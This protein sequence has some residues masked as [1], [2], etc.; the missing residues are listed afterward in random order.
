LWA[1]LRKLSWLIK[2]LLGHDAGNVAILFAICSPILVLGV[3]GGIDLARAYAG[4]QELTQVANLGCQ[5]ASRPSIIQLASQ[6]GGGPTYVSKVNGF[7]TASLTS[8][9]FAFTQSNSTPFSYTANGPANV[10]LNSTVPTVF[11]QIVHVTTIPISAT[12]HCYDTPSAVPQIVPNGNST[13]LVQEGFENTAICPSGYCFVNASGGIGTVATPTS[14]ASTTTSYT[15]ATGGVWHTTGY[16][17]EIDHVGVIKSTVAEGSFSAELDCDNGSGTAGNS[18]ISTEIY[19]PAGSY[20]LRYN[21][22]SRVDYPHYDPTYLCGTT[23]GDLTWANDTYSPTDPVTQAALRTNQINVYLDKDTTGSPPL[24][25]TMLG[26]QQLAGSNLI[27]M[28]VYSQNWVERSIRINISTAGNYWL[29]FAADG[30][31]DSYGGQLDN[32]RFC[33]GTCSGSVQDNFPSAWTSNPTLFEDTFESPV[34]AANLTAYANTQGNLNTSYGTSGVSSGWPSQSA[35]G[36]ATAPYNEVTYN[37]GSLYAQQGTQAVELD[38]YNTS[39]SNRAIS[40]SF[41][42]DPGY[43]KVSYYYISDALFSGA[44]TS[45]A[46]APNAATVAGYV[47]SGTA[48]G[49]VRFSPSSVYTLNK[50]TNLLGVFMSNGQMVSTPIGGGSLNSQTSFNNPDGSVST[51]PTVSPYAISL[52]NYNTSQN[53]PLIDICGYAASWQ[54]RTAYVAVTKPG[55]YWL[56]F[57][58]LGTGDEIGGAIDDVKL[59]AIGSLYGSAPS[60]AVTIPVPSPQPGTSYTNSGAFN[61]FSITADP[62]TVPAP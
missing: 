57:A 43:Y 1:Q 14:S 4:S 29:S 53:N 58:A 50:D 54:P 24:H 23:A 3:G 35:T 2:H 52:S 20:E 28:C 42:L 59:T 8:Q 30:L 21:Y 11:S 49:T 44:S 31:S 46:V 51:T 10:T 33:N 6:S 9:H 15:G 38:S 22:V 60:S 62:L 55:Y 19:L 18:S 56:T 12:A 32:I 7:I 41:L 39:S 45:C 5:F 34:Y 36:W 26:S 13:L 37:L 17:L 16:C 61:G 48:S 27:D 40:R 25:T 47:I